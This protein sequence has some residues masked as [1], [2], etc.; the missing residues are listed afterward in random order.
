MAAEGFDRTDKLERDRKTMILIAHDFFHSWRQVL[1]H[2]YGGSV[3][4]ELTL[5][6][7]E[8]VGKNTAA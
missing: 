3:T 5:R 4:E 7:W 1:Y 8:H 2:Q 6:F